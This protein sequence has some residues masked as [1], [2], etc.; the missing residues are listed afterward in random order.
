M[1]SVEDAENGTHKD[2]TDK[3]GEF[4]SIEILRNS[5]TVRKPVEGRD[6]LLLELLLLLHNKKLLPTPND[7]IKESYFFPRIIFSRKPTTLA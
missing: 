5:G 2:N 1:K 6:R 3:V 7:S 4:S